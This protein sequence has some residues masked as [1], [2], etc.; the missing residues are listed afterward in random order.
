MTK[1]ILLQRLSI[2]KHLYQHGQA[3]SVLS[4]TIAYSSVLTF[5]DAIDMFNQLAAE[6]LGKTAA[7]IKAVTGQKRGLF[8]MEYFTLIPQLTL[9]ASVRK[10]N[11]RRNS[12]K[13]NGQLPAR[14]DIDECKVIA[15]LF[16][17]QNT[18]AI[19]GVPLEEAS[20]SILI[21]DQKVKEYLNSAEKL[22]S[23]HDYIKCVKEVAI[24]FDFL[25]NKHYQYWHK[26]REKFGQERLFIPI[27]SFDREHNFSI[28]FDHIGWIDGGNLPIPSGLAGMIYII[29][30]NFGQLFN[31]LDAFTYG[32]DYGELSYFQMFMP[33]VAGTNDEGDVYIVTET[34]KGVNITQDKCRFAIDFVIKF[35]L[36]YKEPENV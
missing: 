28:N 27:P 12:L 23:E 11:D 20:L 3:Q 7:E 36:S 21:N 15:K 31:S 1:E 18:I 8:M 5:H 32:V 26:Q 25:K 34:R 6:Y 30:R 13:H 29:N 14:I 24:A 33:V 19:F 10:I 22:L 17:E 16:L 2:I 35:A 4:E 9:E